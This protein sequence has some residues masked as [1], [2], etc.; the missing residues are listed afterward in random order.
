[1]LQ[2]V[3]QQIFVRPIAALPFQALLGLNPANISY[4]L[5]LLALFSIFPRAKLQRLDDISQLNPFN[6]FLRLGNQDF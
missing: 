3:L 6:E 1:M 2:S 5:I 4:A